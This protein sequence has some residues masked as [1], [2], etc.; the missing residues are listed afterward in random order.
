MNAAMTKLGIDAFV[1]EWDAPNRVRTLITTR[2][3]GVSL[4]PYASLNLGAH[5][6]DL[7]QNVLANRMLLRKH[8]PSD[9]IWLKQVHGNQ[10]STPT[11]RLSEADA[12]VS[13]VSNEVL[14]IMTAD[15]LPVLFTNRAG[16]V[17]GAAHAGWRGLC[18]GVLENTVKAMR[19]LVTSGDNDILAWLGPAI[20]PQVFE[21]GQDV[22]QAF[23]NFGT[24][25]PQEA[26]IPIDHKPG[27]YLANIYL[28]AR[29]RLQAAGVDQ[30][31]GGQY[32][33]V[34][35]SDQFFSY[36]RDGVTGRFV[37]LVWIAKG[38]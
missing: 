29:S 18:A 22:V 4:R 15:C 12:I 26:F 35:Q 5:V 37:S 1:A 6:G 28:L 17:V 32:C 31:S 36:R 19:E 13:N 16:T 14:A 7:P 27:K 25:Y 33:T 20:G 8:L 30:I 23:E 2:D 21:V 34:S 9:P 24:A 11:T 38:K 3:G 10:V